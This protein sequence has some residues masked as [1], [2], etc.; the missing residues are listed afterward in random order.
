MLMSVNTAIDAPRTTTEIMSEKFL[1]I[2]PNIP[3]LIATVIAFIIVFFIL[4]YLLYKPIKK[5][6]VNRHNFI[7]SNINDSINSKNEAISLVN[8]ANEKL[9]KAHKQADVVVNKAKIEAENVLVSYANKA[10]IDSK[11][12]LEETS[13][14]IENQKKEFEKESKKRIVETAIVLAK[15]IIQKDISKESQ[16]DVIENFLNSNIDIKEI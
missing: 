2:F 7:Q 4:T 14:D 5:M 6:M 9:K 13:R 12:M 3:M 8:E 16:K 15:K 10:K 11:H 1:K